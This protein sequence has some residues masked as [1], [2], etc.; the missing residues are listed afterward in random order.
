MA[1]AYSYGRVSHAD[2]VDSDS[3]PAQSERTK[4]YYESALKESRIKWG[5]FFHDEKNVSASKKPFFKRK[6]GRK[7][8]DLLQPGDHIIFD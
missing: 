5:G 6:A 8:I 2:Q 3:V 1:T 7:L 4:R